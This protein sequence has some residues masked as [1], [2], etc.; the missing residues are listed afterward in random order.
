L[1]FP[2]LLDPRGEIASR[3]GVRGVP[4][5]YFLDPENRIRHVSV[6]YTSPPGLHWRMWLSE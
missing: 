5:L 4:T 2:V 6:G 1:E 3:W